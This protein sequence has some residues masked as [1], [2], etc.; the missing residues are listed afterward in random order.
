LHRRSRS[1]VVRTWQFE[2]C[3]NIAKLSHDSRT[4]RCRL[5]PLLTCFL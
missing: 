2:P 3:N 5:I 1:L 4:I